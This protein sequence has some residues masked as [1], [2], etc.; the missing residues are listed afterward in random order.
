MHIC[1]R[2]IIGYR[3]PEYHDDLKDLTIRQREEY[4]KNQIRESK[5][6]MALYL[7]RVM[8]KIKG[9]GCILAAHHYGP[10]FHGHWIVFLIYPQDGRAVILDSLRENNKEGYK[11]F[12]DCL[13]L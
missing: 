5:L 12:E 1:E 6:H 4:W 13:K 8:K 11:H 3:K 7:L 9:S 10:S 2:V